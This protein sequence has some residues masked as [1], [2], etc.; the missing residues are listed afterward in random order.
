M[1]FLF[2]QFTVFTF[3]WLLLCLALGAGY[4]FVIY[5]LPKKDEGN[6]RKD[7]L[8]FA[9]RT[10]AVS[11]IA[12]LLIAPP[13]KL[14]E[15]TVEKPL[16]LIAQDNSASLQI[17]QAANFNKK[18][19][20][21]ALRNIKSELGSEYD[22]EEVNFGSA[23]RE[24][25]AF[26]FREQQTN[27]SAVFQYVNN[28]YGGRNVGAVILASDG[29]YNK[30]GNP[31]DEAEKLK[32][33]V[34][35]IALGDTIPK[36]DLLISN[37]NYNSIVY[38]GNQFQAEVTI[39]AY[40]CKGLSTS[41]TVTGKGGRL[42]S[43]PIS[44]TSNNFK[45]TVLLSLPASE[46]GI[47]KFVFNLSPVASELSLKNNARAIFVEV[48]DGKQKIL[49][50][51]N[52]PHPD[53]GALKQSIE[54]NKNYEVK[55]DFA[56]DFQIKDFND[57]GLVILHQLPSQLNNLQL[58]N[59]RLSEKPVWFILGSQSNTSRFSQIQ[60]ILNIVSNGTSQETLPVLADNFFVFRLSN[61]TKALIPSLPP[62]ISPFGNYALKDQTS[63]LLN[64]QIG[65][66]Q[67]NSPLLLVADDSRNRTAILTGE[68]IWRWRL[69]N[70]Q[71]KGNHEAIDELV[72]KV[73]QYLSARNDRRKFKAYP[74]KS[75]FE[76]NENV[77]FNAE[78]YNDAY[79]L[80]NTPDVSL[81]IKSAGKNYNFTFSREGAS[82]RLD[83]GTLPAGEYSYEAQTKL[84]IATHQAKGRFVIAENN[85]EYMQTTANHQLLYSLANQ[86]SGQLIYPNEIG[87]L[88]ELLRKNELVKTVSYENRR[89]EDLINLK[90][91][92][93]L[94]LL[95]LGTEWFIRKRE[96]LL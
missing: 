81:A 17:S 57:A 13:L 91:I 69:E 5:S 19:Y 87:K 29:I 67:T 82:Y 53:I 90:V 45:Q 96:G 25:L 93:G 70:F 6:K 54:S 75:M 50:L 71:Q 43:R 23:I 26:N 63:V 20:E 33:A 48:I 79:E 39:E 37:I 86:S 49:I 10:L 27:L 42:V 30:G 35:A 36:R 18:D 11:I 58:L 60:K 28:R 46:K 65:R 84:G 7:W 92:F 73:I 24:G 15:K 21:T 78:L 89:Y 85:A 52:S 22:V 76:E 4:A 3:L 44:I 16:V 95:L 88:P 64:Q 72:S 59:N 77:V 55:V 9:F 56:A 80:V 34:Y 1:P 51:A 14:T 38:S 66:V 74:A 94:V 68:G 62:L 12:F 61:N 31:Q 32:T 47:E 41:L 40:Q 2:L 83:A 8:L